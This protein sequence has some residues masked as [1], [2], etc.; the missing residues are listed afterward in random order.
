MIWVV[1]FS[2]KVMLDWVR[3][4]KKNKTTLKTLCVRINKCKREY[5]TCAR[6]CVEQRGRWC[7]WRV[8]IGRAICGDRPSAS[9]PAATLFVAMPTPSTIP[10][11]A[12]AKTA[13]SSFWSA[14]GQGRDLTLVCIKTHT[15]THVHLTKIR[16]TQS[17][18]HFLFFASLP[19]CSEIGCCLTGSP[20]WS[21]VPSSCVCMRKRRC[22]VTISPST[23]SS[24]SCILCTTSV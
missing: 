2:G 16:F 1:H 5:N 10:H 15:H 14:L 12:W 21:S 23:F 13:N 17:V 7:I 11:A 22:C 8:L 20:C 3:A 18:L 19:L 4:C 9:V 24:A 6:S